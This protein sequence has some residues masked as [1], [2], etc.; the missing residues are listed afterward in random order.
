[1]KLAT[2]VVLLI[3][4]GGAG[5]W[6]A[7]PSDICAEAE[8]LARPLVESGTVVGMTVALVRE[9]RTEIFGLGRMGANDARQPNGET[10]FEIGSVSKVFTGLLLADAIERGEV[11]LDDV[12]GKYLPNDVAMPT[13]DDRPIRLV[14]LVTHTSG[15]P[16]LPDNLMPQI[17][18]HP[19]NPYAQYTVAQLHEAVAAQK[20]ASTPG[21]RFVY[22]NYGMGLLGHL[23]ARRAGMSYEA[24]VIDRIAGPLKMNDTRIALDESR[25]GR[26][27]R[28]HDG[29]GS[30]VE[31][32]DIPTLAGAGALRSTAADQARFIAAQLKPD[33]TPLGPAIARSHKS[34][35]EVRKGEGAAMGWI[36]RGDPPVIW[37]NGQTGGYHSFVGFEPSKQTGVVVLSNTAGNIT[38]ELGFRLLRL[39]AGEKVEPLTVRMPKA[40]TAEQ[41]DR[42]A[43]TYQSMP[44]FTFI[45]T[46][47]G[48]RLLASLS[49]QPAARIFPESESKFFYRAVDAEITFDFGD[50]GKPSKLVLHQHGL[51][52][53]AWRGGLGGMAAKAVFKPR[54]S[55]DEAVKADEQ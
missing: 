8:A 55:S 43:G 10:V 47:D 38:D 53:P 27:A 50:D 12:L 2:T 18:E 19:E 48:D 21:K 41:L 5:A 1:M 6:A 26:L 28:G 24:L 34:C 23:L 31:N 32:W 11:A 36:V 51:R 14:D 33:G 25:R 16:R 40:L 39:L 4:L 29:D 54:S 46:R 22:S 17:A 52:L 35:F 37:H 9:G 49:G 20:L 7:P 44:S 42:Y 15:L 3:G 13:K 30:P 45:I